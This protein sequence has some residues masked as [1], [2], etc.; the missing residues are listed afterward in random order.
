MVVHAAHIQ[1][2]EGAK[3]V[4]RRA[5]GRFPRLR[6]IWAD[7]GYKAHFVAW[8]Q[9]VT[10]WAVELVA[11]PAGTKGFRVLPRRWVVERTFAWLGRNRRL[12]K[13]YEGR[14]ETHEAWVQVAMIHLMLKRLAPP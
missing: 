9:A 13:D 2:S 11:R 5:L 14:P 8:A 7:Q 6:L 4:L 1:D 3:L 10:G 12:S